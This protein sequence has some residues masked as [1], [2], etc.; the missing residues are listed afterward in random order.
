MVF[1]FLEL[2]FLIAGCLRSGFKEA[3]PEKNSMHRDLL[4]AKP[5]SR[6]SLKGRE[7]SKIKEGNE[8]SGDVVSGLV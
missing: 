6:K 2:H 1:T 7:G 5:L 4:M 3:G 8:P